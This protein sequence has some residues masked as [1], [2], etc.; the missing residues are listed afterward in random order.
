M[1]IDDLNLLEPHGAE[2]FL[3]EH[4]FCDLFERGILSDADREL[5]TVAILSAL[6]GVEAQLAAHRAIAKRLGLSDE[7]YAELQTLLHP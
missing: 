7:A 4:L 2:K 6:P 5:R 1:V 3:Q